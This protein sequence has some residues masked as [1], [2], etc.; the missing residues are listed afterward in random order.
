MTRAWPMPAVRSVGVRDVTGDGAGGGTRTPNRPITNR[1]LYQLS[2]TSTAARFTRNAT[3]VNRGASTEGAST[4]GAS[5][6]GAS[7]EGASTE[8]ASTEGAS[9]EGRQQRG[10]QQRGRQ[11]RGRQQRGRQ[12]RGRQ[13]R[14]RQQRGVNRGGV[15]REGRQQSGADQ[16][17]ISVAIAQSRLPPRERARGAKSTSLMMPAS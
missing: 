11:Q 3:F 8:G 4:E 9:T 7:T 10:R 14:G 2:H 1:V 13:Q 12:Q 16:Y 15:N 17:I 6:E 5:T